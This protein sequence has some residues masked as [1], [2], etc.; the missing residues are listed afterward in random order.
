MPSPLNTTRNQQLT[1]VPQ[2]PAP[3]A[4]TRIPY[5]P[6]PGFFPPTHSTIKQP[7]QPVITVQPNATTGLRPPHGTPV[8]PTGVTGASTSLASCAFPPYSVMTHASLPEALKTFDGL[9][10]TYTPD[11]H[12]IAIS[13]RL[14]Y[15]LRPEPTDRTE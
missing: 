2:P 12:L 10:H 11:D 1:I 4:L 6:A 14:T 13:A 3:N 15:E 5:T 7:P 8:P 9:D